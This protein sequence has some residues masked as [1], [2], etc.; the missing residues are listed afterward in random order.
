MSLAAGGVSIQ[1]AWDHLSRVPDF[2]DIEREEFDRLVAWM[3]RDGSMIL[4]SGLL[5]LGPKAERRFGRRNF[6]ELFAVFSS[7]RTYSVATT[8]GQPLGSLTQEFVDRLVCDVSSFLLGGRA[9]AVSQI[10]HDEHC[11]VVLPSPIGRQPSWGGFLPQFLG[12]ELCQQV[13]RVVA[14]EQSYNYLDAQALAV[15]QEQ[16]SALSGFLDP[17]HGGIEA[18][19]GELRW[20]TFAGSRINSTLRYALDALEPAWTVIPD[21]YVIRIRGASDSGAWLSETI[22]QLSQDS[23]WADEALWT[24]IRKS[25]P[26]YR[27]SK[28]QPLMPDWVEQ[29]LLEYHLLDVPGAHTCLTR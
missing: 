28:F 15:L 12:K 8:S 25:L 4:T 10:Q 9:W 23:F 21:N 20:W 3:I 1:A 24:L 2:C 22:E 5:S 18:D 6:M 11:V 13:L 14:T 19:E 7:P 17:E 26:N 16:R 27:L 29:E